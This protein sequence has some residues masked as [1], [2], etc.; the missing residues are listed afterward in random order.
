VLYQNSIKENASGGDPFFEPAIQQL[1]QALL[2]L[3]RATNY[4]DLAMCYALIQLSDLEKRLLEATRKKE[5][6]L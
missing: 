4:P 3:A 2:Q 5:R 1:L 6:V